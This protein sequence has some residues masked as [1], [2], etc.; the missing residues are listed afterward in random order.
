MAR[1]GEYLPESLAYAL[2]LR[3][4]HLRLLRGSSWAYRRYWFANHG[5]K[6]VW[7]S[8]MLQELLTD[9]PARKS[10][11]ISMADSEHPCP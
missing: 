8:G 11:S 4:R 7:G 1:R 9:F 10:L 2:T 6:D 5:E 3:L